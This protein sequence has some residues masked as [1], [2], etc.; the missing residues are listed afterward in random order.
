MV[1]VPC[2]KKIIFNKRAL[3][4][5]HIAVEMIKADGRSSADND[6]GRQ[7]STRSE[8]NGN[9]RQRRPIICSMIGRPTING[10]IKANDM[11]I[12]GETSS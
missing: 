2:F 9:G 3:N 12:R 7:R 11:Q 6:N 1:L 10:M 5:L 4:N 8:V